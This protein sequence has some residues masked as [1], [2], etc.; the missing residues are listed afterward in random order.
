MLPDRVSNPGP[1]T[2]ESGA[3]PTA[4]RGPAPKEKSEHSLQCLPIHLSLLDSFCI[5]K[6]KCCIFKTIILTLLHSEWPKLY[7]VLAKT[8][9]SFG[10]AECNRVNLRCPSYLNSYTI[11][12]TFPDQAH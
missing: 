11:S 4:L 3:L 10:H 5:E 9:W 1:L 6:R 2:Y 8:L 12:T 7:G